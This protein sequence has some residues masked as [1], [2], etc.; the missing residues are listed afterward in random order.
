LGKQFDKSIYESEFYRIAD[1]LNMDKQIVVNGEY[2]KR[3]IVQDNEVKLKLEFIYEMLPRIGE[4]Q[5]I[6][7]VWIDT[8]ENVT[9]NKLTAIYSRNTY[10]DYYDLFF[11]LREIDLAK[12]LKDSESK[13]VPLDYEG[14]LMSLRGELQERVLTI[15]EFDKVAYYQFIKD[16]QR[17]LLEYAKGSQ[18]LF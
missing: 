10:K 3:I 2:F 4:P 6:D 18:R 13:M 15:N 9:S 1:R 5:K 17:K 12:A 16:L 8:K 14:A 11:L 7:N